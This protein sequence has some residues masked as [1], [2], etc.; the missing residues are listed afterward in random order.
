MT[1]LKS[2]RVQFASA[3][4]G[5]A[6]IGGGSAGPVLASDE[7]TPDLGEARVCT[8]ASL[9]GTYG[10]TFDGAIV[11]SDGTHVAEFAGVGVETFDGHGNISSGRLIGT[12]NGQPFTPTFSGTYSIRADCT[13]T[14][15]I[16]INGQPSHYAVVVV[17]RGRQIETAETDPGT[18]L[19][20][21]QTLQ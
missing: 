3:L 2:A 5:L 21:T 12:N 13:G 19:V 9:S 16:S 8:D 7:D 1:R 4:A 14:K 20:F 17:A 6:L 18:Q 11:K 10:F 15:T